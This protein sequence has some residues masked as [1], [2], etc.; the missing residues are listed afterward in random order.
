MPGKE[1]FLVKIYSVAICTTDL[2]VIS[3]GPPIL[4]EGG[5]TF[6]NNF[7]IERQLRADFTLN[8]KNE[9]DVVQSVK[10]SLKKGF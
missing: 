3:Y 9:K 5:S 8:V 1:E 4:I 6:N 10:N 2:D 7:E